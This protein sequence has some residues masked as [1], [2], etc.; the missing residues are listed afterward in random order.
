MDVVEPIEDWLSED[1]INNI[2]PA[3]MEGKIGGV[4]YGLPVAGLGYYIIA[5]TSWIKLPRPM[6]RC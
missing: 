3:L 2:D 5:L 1:L 6:K 4:L